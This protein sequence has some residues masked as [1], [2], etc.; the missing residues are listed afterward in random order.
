MSYEDDCAG[1]VSVC[2]EGG[3]YVGELECVWMGGARKMILGFGEK[4]V[5]L[6]LV[7]QDR[8]RLGNDICRT[9]VGQYKM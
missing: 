9:V 2:C 3:V 4:S 8:M 7:R 6:S 1:S 5:S